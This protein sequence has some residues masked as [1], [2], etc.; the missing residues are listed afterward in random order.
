MLQERYARSL[1]SLGMTSLM[2]TLLATNNEL[3]ALHADFAIRIDRVMT[4][5]DQRILRTRSQPHELHDLPIRTPRT[6]LG[7]SVRAALLLLHAILLPRH[8][9][10]TRQSNRHAV[11]TNM[12]VA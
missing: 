12:N 8:R 1:A 5:R 11:N 9:P 10:H 6:H 3:I 7:L 2:V 4:P